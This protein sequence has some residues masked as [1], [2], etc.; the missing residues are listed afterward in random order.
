MWQGDAPATVFARLGRIVVGLALVVHQGH[1][2]AAAAAVLLAWEDSNYKVA[3]L[4]R[5][6]DTQH[7]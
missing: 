5:Q 3:G 2:A 4:D 7:G 6:T 1:V